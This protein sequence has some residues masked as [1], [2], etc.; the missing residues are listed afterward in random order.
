MPR[1]PKFTTQRLASSVV[2]TPGVSNAGAELARDIA[3]SADVVFRTNIALTKAQ[4]NEKLTQ[5]ELDLDEL[6]Q[7]NREENAGNPG[8]IT[9]AFKEKARNLL[10]NSL[11]GVT[12]G[13][14]RQ[15]VNRLG[16]N[17]IQNRQIN[18]QRHE[19]NQKVSLSFDKTMSTMDAIG[20]EAFNRARR[21]DVEGAFSQT[22]PGLQRAFETSADILPADKQEEIR[23]AGLK[24]RAT[25]AL[26]GALESDNPAM[27]MEL[28]KDER[29]AEQLTAGEIKNFRSRARRATQNLEAKIQLEDRIQT[30][31][32]DAE[33]F[34]GVILGEK[35]LA[36]VQALPEGKS[37][38]LAEEYLLVDRPEKSPTEKAKAYTALWTVYQGI[39]D[40]IEENPS[41]LSLEQIINF[42]N[43]AV[44]AQIDGVISESKLQTMLGSFA[45]TLF[46]KVE[47]TDGRFK[48]IPVVD[49]IKKNFFGKD[50]RIPETSLDAGFQVID[51]WLEN[52][53]RGEDLQAKAELLDSFVTQHGRLKIEN[54]DEAYDLSQ[55]VIQQFIREE[56]PELGMLP[57]TPNSVMKETGRVDILPGQSKLKPE[58]KVKQAF[59]IG[60]HTD[61]QTGEQTRVR[62]FPDGTIE[63]VK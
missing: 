18:E 31:A 36:D 37:R 10:N 21:G 51:G 58:A 34:R 48:S 47:E 32:Q 24:N 12:N 6:A 63:A 40:S 46:E 54:I 50:T 17:T 61:P 23:V 13:A 15:E 28:L 35:N 60:V 25:G 59:K 27:V 41:E 2:G 62:V 22:D 19:H 29:V 5:F 57:A 11:T 44:Q 33:F 45:P 39:K 42:Q 16:R 43:D 9:S 52:S 49:F 55:K 56:H 26:Y 3:Q 53:G 1:I 38:D 30:F 8:N 7:Q 20:R 4:T 14:V